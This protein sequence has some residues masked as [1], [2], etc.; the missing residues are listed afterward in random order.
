[1]SVEMIY[2]FEQDCAC[3]RPVAVRV[4]EDDRASLKPIAGRVNMSAGQPVAEKTIGGIK[5]KVFVS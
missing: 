4:C 2:E 1:M 5:V 3:P